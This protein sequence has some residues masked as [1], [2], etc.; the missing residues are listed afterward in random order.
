[1]DSMREIAA[2][3]GSHYAKHTTTRMMLCDLLVAAALATVAIQ[4]V[5]CMLFG[6]YPFNSFL[7]GFFGSLG[8]AVLTVSLRLQLGPSTEFKVRA[9]RE[10]KRPSR[11]ATGSRR[12]LGPE[13][14]RLSS[15]RQPRSSC[16]A[17]GSLFEGGRSN[18]PRTVTL[19]TLVEIHPVHTP[20]FRSRLH[21]RL[22]ALQRQRGHL[23]EDRAAERRA[24]GQH[25]PR[26]QDG[27]RCP[28]NGPRLEEGGPFQT[29]HDQRGHE[30]RRHGHQNARRDHLEEAR[31]SHHSRRSETSAA[32]QGSGSGRGRGRGRAAVWA[33]ML[34]SRTPWTTGQSTYLGCFLGLPDG[35][36]LR[37]LH[38]NAL[39]NLPLTHEGHVDAVGGC[40]RD[41]GD[42]S[43]NQALGQGRRAGD[44]PVEGHGGRDRGG[45]CS[46]V[47]LHQLLVGHARRGVAVGVVHNGVEA[48]VRPLPE[49]HRRC[50]T[51]LLVRLPRRRGRFHST[52]SKA[53]YPSDAHVARHLEAHAAGKEE[54]LA[55]IR[56]ER[57]VIELLSRPHLVICHALGLLSLAIRFYQLLGLV[58]LLIGGLDPAAPEFGPV[59]TSE[60]SHKLDKQGTH[61]HIQGVGGAPEVLQPALKVALV[62]ARLVQVQAGHFRPAGQRVRQ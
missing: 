40:N 55:G 57:A 27:E 1:M 6:S 22:Q 62:I 23:R 45:R 50:R 8:V 52:R 28:Q 25:G 59:T 39:Q 5:Y 53:T 7:A 29:L 56:V 36:A 30:H 43:A 58:E 3:F 48:L 11:L 24:E 31:L 21:F 9:R 60:A 12:L 17:D 13:T 47:C 37:V 35:D 38:V 44:Q 20:S 41:H 49:D 26:E 34:A 54:L 61:Q 2:G 15:Y 14:S 51:L 10:E 33:L 18:V 4:A 16:F 46:R 19:Q 32:R 42:E